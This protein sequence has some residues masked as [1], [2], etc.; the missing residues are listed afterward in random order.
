MKK[1]KHILFSIYL[2]IAI[3][4]TITLLAY[5]DYKITQ[6]GDYSLLIIKDDE[7]EP[8]FKEGD[9]VIL[10]KSA[11]ILTGRKAFFYDTL[12]Q[13]IEVKLG[14]IEA[15][16]RVNKDEITYT[17]EGER[18]I[19]SEYV[20]G[21][22]NSAEVIPTLGK[23]L[24]ILQSKWGFLFII[25]FPALILVV[26]QIGVVCNNI[27]ESLKEAKKESKQEGKSS[28]DSKEWYKNEKK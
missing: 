15:A 2:I 27:I 24:G 7:L 19:S 11:S 22:A 16:E 5:N 26:N 13:K 3:L 12:N 21:P 1:L 23:V 8:D 28:E 4:L 20:L 10:N 17:L 25:V 18:K 6:F 14:V 9:L